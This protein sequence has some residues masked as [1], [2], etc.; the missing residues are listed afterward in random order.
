V[1]KEENTME[2]ETL[3]KFCGT[4]F[5][6]WIKAPWNREGSTYAT[7][8]HVILRVSALPD[9]VERT[10]DKV[11]ELPWSTLAKRSTFRLLPGTFNAVRERFL[12]RKC[13]PDAALAKPCTKCE[14]KD[15]GEDCLACG[16]V[17][18]E[19]EKG[20][21]QWKTSQ[22]PECDGTRW[23]EKSVWCLRNHD[24]VDKRY[25]L[26]PRILQKMVENLG[27]IEF[28]EFEKNKPVGFRFAGGDGL[29]MPM[30]PAPWHIAANI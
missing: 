11:K 13:V 20:Q 27:P 18:L 25:Y 10:I 28:V 4:D 3:K 22:C 12:C 14:G 8:G 9:N 1:R 24:E 21:E 2:I 7:D 6:E 30:R 29:L 17:G 5:P 15:S 26:N 19:K 23:R 16:G